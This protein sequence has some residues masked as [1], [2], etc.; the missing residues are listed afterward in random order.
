MT[1][2]V[3]GLGCAL[4]SRRLTNADLEA[5][6]DTT[7]RWI[8]ERTGIRERR[9]AGPD[10]TTASLATAAGGAA[11]KDA[12]L[13]PD[14]IDL[15]VLA[16]CTPDQQLPHTSARVQ[17]ALGLRCGALDLGA[18]CAGFVYALGFAASIVE[19]GRAEHVVVVGAETLSRIIDPD[20]R[21]TAVLFG[22]GAGAC[23]VSR[24]DQPG[25]LLSWHVGCDGAAADLL[26]IPPEAGF[27]QM[28]GPEVFRRAVRVVVESAAAALARAGLAAEDVGL[29][30]P[31]QANIRII[32]AA[33][34]RL[35][36]PME[37]VVVNIERY[38]NTSAASIPIALHEAVTAGRL[39]AGDVVLMSGFGAGMT[40]ASATLRWGAA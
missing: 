25:G 7:D 8:V 16:T 33:A 5:R 14:D 24:S 26:Q 11:I 21:G 40:Y 34:E 19:T 39:S 32:Q 20:D 17:D 37:R 29:F 31:H 36:I 2:T 9:I 10:D 38:G 22:D 12:G 15:L 30:V 28:D 27:L 23:V 1:A 13:T 4:P 18:A 35:G 3:T 6:V